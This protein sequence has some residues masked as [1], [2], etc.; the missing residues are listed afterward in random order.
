MLPICS[1]RAFPKPASN[2]CAN[3]WVSLKRKFDG[4]L[5]EGECWRSGGYP[6]YASLFGDSPACLSL[7]FV[8]CTFL[9][10]LFFSIIAHIPYC[11]S[12]RCMLRDL[13]LPNIYIKIPASYIMHHHFFSWSYNWICSPLHNLYLYCA[14]KNHQVAKCP[15]VPSQQS[16]ITLPS[17]N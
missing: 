16:N 5:D 3:T 4:C 10:F 11:S 9:F 1:P 17:K 7:S 6:P 15:M 13:V 14:N 12:A 8:L 2:S